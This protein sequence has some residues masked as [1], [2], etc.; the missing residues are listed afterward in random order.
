MKILR[1]QF[2]NISIFS[3]GLDIDFTAQDRITDESGV[4]RI[5]GP[6]SVSQSI[7]IIGINAVGKTT[8]LRLMRIAL[9]TVVN[10]RNLNNDLSPSV[11]INQRSIK[12]GIEMIVH[13]YKDEKV[14]KLNSYIRFKKDEKDSAKLYYTDEILSYKNINKVQN[15]KDIFNFSDE[16]VEKTI[17]RNNLK[18][19]ESRFLKEDDSIAIIATRGNTV[20]T[21]YM[22]DGEA[23]DITDITGSVDK[24]ILNVF[25]SNLKTVE[26]VADDNVKIEFKNSQNSYQVSQPFLRQLI[27]AGTI[28]GQSIIKS[29]ITA[30]KSGG[31]LV[32]DELENHFN[33]ELVKVVISIFDEPKINKKGAT[34]IFTTHYAEIL[35]S[36]TRKDNIYVLRRNKNLVTDIVRYSDKIKRS[37]LKKSEVILSNYIKGTAPKAVSIR[38]LKEFICESV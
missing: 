13:F 4:F 14:Y 1:V 33:K 36:F 37:E 35:D 3:E 9:D 23:S 28:K 22:L 29:A 15:K 10:N 16:V 24:N 18:E 32:I 34:L 7:A 20:T 38:N 26:A 2:K 27:S 6:L 21:N 8:A 17:S 19:E 31:Y 30:L 11:L 12:E 5:S 25:D